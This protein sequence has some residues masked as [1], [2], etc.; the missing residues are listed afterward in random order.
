M[1]VMAYQS[2]F[3]SH[4][5]N[6]LGAALGKSR[7]PFLFIYA[8][9]EDSFVGSPVKG[10][11]IQQSTALLHGPGLCAPHAEPC[12]SVLRS[13]ARSVQLSIAPRRSWA[14]AG[15]KAEIAQPS[16]AQVQAASGECLSVKSTGQTRVA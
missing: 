13:R 14:M 10:R 5:S 7:K 12:C 15:S 4:I 2:P 1:D 11:C 3:I 9:L 16:L 8:L 6:N